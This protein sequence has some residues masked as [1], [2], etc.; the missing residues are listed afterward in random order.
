MGGTSMGWGDSEKKS[1]TKDEVQNG[2]EE[3]ITQ[4]QNPIYL[5]L[6]LAQ[7]IIFSSHNSFEYEKRDCNSH[8]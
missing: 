8:Q 1:L 7:N 3:K 6:T 2:G 5:N 4:T